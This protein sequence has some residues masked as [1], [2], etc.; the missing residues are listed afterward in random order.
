MGRSTATSLWTW[1]GVELGAGNDDVDVTVVRLFTVES[2]SYVSRRS[3]AADS[4]SCC[5]N[6]AVRA[7]ISF[8]ISTKKSSKTKSKKR[9]NPINQSGF[10]D[11]DCVDGG[12][13]LAQVQIK[14]HC[15]MLY[16]F[17][18][19]REHNPK[20]CERE[21]NRKKRREKNKNK[22]SAWACVHLHSARAAWLC[23]YG[24]T[25]LRWLSIYQRST[26]RIPTSYIVTNK[27]AWACL[28]TKN[29]LLICT[30]ALYADHGK[31]RESVQ[32]LVIGAESLFTHVGAL[33][34]DVL[35]AFPTIPTPFSSLG[36]MSMNWAQLLS[37]SFFIFPLNFFAK[38]KNCYHVID[39]S[40]MFVFRC[41]QKAALKE[42]ILFFRLTF[43]VLAHNCDQD[44]RKCDQKNGARIRPEKCCD[45]HR[46]DFSSHAIWSTTFSWHY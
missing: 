23:Y 36:F 25:E 41:V 31:R 9:S 6:N 21:D 43:W 7:A 14:V 22:M 35:S 20:A 24:N 1:A 2:N 13:G 11:G 15:A 17:P 10:A 18:I 44:E 37:S 33:I 16:P 19:R 5:L 8:S 12:A 40:M 39:A 28:R 26:Q 29:C 34:A 42:K 32:V 30:N 3:R 4:S 27:L 46:K 45:W 38:K